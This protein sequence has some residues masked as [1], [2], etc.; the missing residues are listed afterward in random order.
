[1]NYQNEFTESEI[2][3][4]AAARLIEDDKSYFIGFG[5]PQIALVLAQKLY[6]PNVLQVYEVGSIAPTI[7]L[8][9]DPLLMADSRGNYRAISWTSM[10]Q[11][12]FHCALGYMDYGVLGINEIDQYG[13]INTTYI[14]GTYHQP[15]KRL[16]GSGGANEIASLCW[17]TIVVAM[18]EKRRFLE[19]LEFITTPGYLDGSP[20]AR[21]K[22]GL[23]KGTGPYRVVTSKAMF[24]FDD[25]TK[26]MKL[27]ATMP[28]ASVDDVLK[29]MQFKPLIAEEVQNIAPPT[30]EE[31][32]LLREEIDP[33]KSIIGKGKLI[34]I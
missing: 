33:S 29:E 12:S 5:M 21:E 15:K 23:P 19:K 6:A 1:M 27:L 11:L 9:F 28:G 26:K 32:R 34:K 20:Q 8:P 25:D 30:E 31:L 18:Q 3:I 4:C 10:N 24:G 13:N 17:K 14:G 22:A 16:S 7:V 2:M